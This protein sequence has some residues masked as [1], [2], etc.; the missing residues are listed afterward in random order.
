MRSRLGGANCARNRQESAV[1]AS[2]VRAF[3]L[4]HSGGTWQVRSIYCTCSKPMSTFPPPGQRVVS[5]TRH[6]VTVSV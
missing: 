3:L 2:E 4:M 5:R 1:V 6:I